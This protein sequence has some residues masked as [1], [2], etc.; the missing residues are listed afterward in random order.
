MQTLGVSGK[1]RQRDENRLKALL[2]PTVESAWDADSIARQGFWVCLLIGACEV[3][4]GIV[5]GTAALNAA[6]ASAFVLLGLIAGL[7]FFLGGMGVRQCS[8][9]AAALIVALFSV[10]LLFSAA[11]GRFPGFLVIV[12]EGL[13][14]ANLR[15]S[16]I[17]SRWS[18][19]QEGED[20]PS[21]FRQTFADKL[22]DQWPTAAWPILRIPFFVLAGLLFL[23]LAA[24]TL[25]ILLVRLGILPNPA[26]P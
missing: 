1:P 13:L 8:W 19:P 25:I 16:V 7:V 9:P 15:A 2:W 3:I 21:R 11:N 6:G 10:H 4:V 12:G 20:R 5:A 26:A 22:A 14:V 24:G 17:A 23:L 18:A